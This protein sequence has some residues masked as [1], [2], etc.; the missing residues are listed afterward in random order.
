MK[1]MKMT[2]AFILERLEVIG[3][4]APEKESGNETA[5]RMLKFLASHKFE[6]E[7]EIKKALTKWNQSEDSFMAWVSEYLLRELKELK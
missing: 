6:N 7:I 2:E 5:E 3:G 1:N 4:S